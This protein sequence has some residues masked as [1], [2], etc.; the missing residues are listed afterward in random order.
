[1]TWIITCLLK[2]VN[3]YLW[4]IWPHKS[5]QRLTCFKS[6]NATALDVLLTNKP[7]CFSVTFNIDMELNDFHNYIGVA[8]KMFAPET[9]KRRVNYRYMRKF[10]DETFAHDVGTI[11]FLVCNIFE[12]VDDISWVQHQLGT[13]N[14]E[15]GFLCG[16]KFFALNISCGEYLQSS[17]HLMLQIWWKPLLWKMCQ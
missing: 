6:W 8:S 15:V 5:Y 14:K 10:D 7:R 12:D 4:H 2:W 1:M 3:W 17:L 13:F 9:M 16:L 11:P